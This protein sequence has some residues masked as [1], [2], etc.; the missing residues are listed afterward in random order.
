MVVARGRQRARW[1]EGAG[2]GVVQLSGGQRAM[3]VIAADDQHFA[4]REQTG[5][6]VGPPSGHRAGR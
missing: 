4:I 1:A 5:G 3:A 6:V 2:L